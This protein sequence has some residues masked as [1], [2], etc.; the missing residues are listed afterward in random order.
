MWL[1]KNKA[2]YRELNKNWVQILP[3]ASKSDGTNTNF[4]SSFVHR[5]LIDGN[6]IVI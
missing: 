5:I 4:P 3:Q 6:A 2:N 1:S